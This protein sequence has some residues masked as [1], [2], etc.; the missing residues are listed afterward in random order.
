VLKES[1]NQTYKQPG[2]LGWLVVA[3]LL[4]LQWGLFR[5]FARREVVWAFPTGF[6]QSVYLV[7]AY[8]TYEHVLARGPLVGFRDALRRQ[9]PAGLLLPIQAAGFFRLLGPSRLSALTLNFATFALLQ[10]AL[11]GTLRRLSGRWSVAFVGLGLLLCAGS[12]YF[13]AGGLF[14]FRM[15]FAALCLFGVVLCAVACSN[16]FESRGFAGLAGCAAALLVLTRFL[17]AVYC[18]GIGGACLLF[19]SL[20]ILHHRNVPA[21]RRCAARQLQGLLLAGLVLAV[22]SLPALWHN[23]HTIWNYYGVGHV[24]GPEK[25]IRAREW[26]VHG[27][28]QALLFYPRSVLVHHAGTVFVTSAA[29]IVLAA[30]VLR[31]FGRRQR[32]AQAQPEALD[33]R[34]LSFFACSALLI[35]LAVLTADVSKSPIVGNVLVA[36]LL[37]LALLPAVQLALACGRG[38]PRLAPR[39]LQ[40]LA[41]VVLAAGVSVQAAALCRH[42]P[43]YAQRQDVEQWLRMYDALDAASRRLTL[44]EV[45]LSA[46]CVLGRADAHTIQASLYERHRHLVN[47]RMLMP[48]G[49]LAVTED[50]AM[51]SLRQSDFV[52][53][54]SSPVPSGAS[55]YPFDRA[56][57][58]MR[59]QLERF[60]EDNLLPVERFR[61]SGQEVILYARATLIRPGSDVVR[62]RRLP[63]EPIP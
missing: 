10:L 37:W 11:V 14:D 25:E 33:V 44:P 47:L 31:F 62:P 2:R 28:N 3:A 34:G 41:V 32:D 19:L 35:P 1:S 63:D 61:V 46:N 13:A 55:V 38:G 7:A 42:G 15:D 8:E 29:V 43:L 26:G 36:P 24:V 39:A 40:G 9:A 56:M 59:P 4:L 30:L 53:V 51:A 16:F 60:C 50:E 20:R 45:R 23:R 22:C 6:D 27:W 52:I 17:T 5:E 54:A 18:A 48:Q 57:D 21:R 58:A 12:P 49:V